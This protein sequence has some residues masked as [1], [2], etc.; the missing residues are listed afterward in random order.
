MLVS[1]SAPL[2]ERDFRRIEAATG[3]RLVE[4]YG[5]TETIMNTAVPVDGARRPGTV[6]PPLPG[7]EVR[8]LDESGSPVAPGDE[9]IG[10]VLVR[11]PNLFLG[12]L[13]P[14]GRDGGGHGRAA[15]SEPATWPRWTPTAI[16]ASW[17]DGP[18]T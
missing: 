16:C 2:A 17:A 11:G 7:V 5:L 4:R 9:A 14:A 13:Q 12:Y 1:G 15:G 3:Q 18:P 6:G 8:V 10:D